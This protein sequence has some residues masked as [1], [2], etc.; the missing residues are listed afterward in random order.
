M[1]SPVR[2]SAQLMPSQRGGPSPRTRTISP[3]K[4]VREEVVEQKVMSFEETLRFGDSIMSD[5]MRY[6]PNLEDDDG[7][8]TTKT[9]FFQESQNL[10]KILTLAG[11]RATRS[12]A[13][14]GDSRLAQSRLEHAQ[15][16]HEINQ[17]PKSKAEIY[18]QLLDVRG[19][20]DVLREKFKKE[21]MAKAKISTMYKLEVQK[22]KKL[23]EKD[24]LSQAD[25]REL[26]KF[27][28]DN[29]IMLKS[30]IAD[31]DNYKRDKELEILRLVQEKEEEKQK[32]AENLHKEHEQAS[33][34]FNR[35]SESRERQHKEAMEAKAE[36]LAKQRAEVEKHKKELESSFLNKI[37]KQQSGFG[38]EK[39]M[40]QKKL[41]ETRMH[42][43]NAKQKAMSIKEKEM[44]EKHN[45]SIVRLKREHREAIAAKDLEIKDREAH[46]E[47][48]VK[49]IQN[50]DVKHDEELQH[51]R[52]II[53]KL[54]KLVRNAK[55]E[56]V[57]VSLHH[58]DEEYEFM[59]R[60]GVPPMGVFEAER[61]KDLV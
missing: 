19:E 45:K 4:P 14:V 35:V 56:M 28:R 18:N 49:F 11:K 10:D 50:A 26:R 16:Y 7:P 38:S 25:L 8:A 34:Q 60:A 59:S 51:L 52:D 32:L 58:M 40:L 54:E 55:V 22:T 37:K 46:I 44:V 48:Q 41:A 5:T 17:L 9:D 12:V 24:K 13:S 3:N 1:T 29:N 33:K 42:L 57:K 23:I 47:E 20:R 53:K 21:H 2:P 43:Q 31:F 39:T 27:R 15:M 6:A 30:T 61:S 36:E